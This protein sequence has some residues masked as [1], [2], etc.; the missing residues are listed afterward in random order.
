MLADEVDAGV[1]GNDRRG[2]AKGWGIIP[3]D[4]DLIENLDEFYESGGLFHP[5]GHWIYKK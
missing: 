3:E 5:E 2:N 4:V 1:A